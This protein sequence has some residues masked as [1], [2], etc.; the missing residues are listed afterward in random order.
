MVFHTCKIIHSCFVI[1]AHFF[2]INNCV[3][4]W[5]FNVLIGL[6]PCFKNETVGNNRRNVCRKKCLKY[7]NLPQLHTLMAKRILLFSFF[8]EVWYCSKFSKMVKEKVVSKN[9]N[10]WV[11]ILF[12]WPLYWRYGYFIFFCQILLYLIT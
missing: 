11:S 5:W 3:L 9:W 1:N 4:F 12:E 8:L 7:K 10:F 6:P 2:F